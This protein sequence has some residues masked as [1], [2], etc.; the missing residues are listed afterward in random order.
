MALSTSFHSQLKEKIAL[1][2]KRIEDTL[3]RLTYIEEKLGE[4]DKKLFEKTIDAHIRGDNIRASMYS[5]EIA[6]IRR[7]RKNILAIKISLERLFLKLETAE[8]LGDLVI[9]IKPSIA[10]LGELKEEIA[11]SMPGLGIEIMRI[12]DLVGDV[13]SILREATGVLANDS[14]S[15]KKEEVDRILEEA[16]SI[17]S[18]KTL[19]DT[20]AQPILSLRGKEKLT[21]V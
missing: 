10:L 6:N 14:S 20:P 11:K 21:M 8:T 5:D 7:M 2:K 12:N 3:S 4:R 18:H 15:I 9:A 16:W 13:D 1:L 17:A 19:I